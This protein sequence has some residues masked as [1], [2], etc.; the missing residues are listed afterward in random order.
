MVSNGAYLGGVRDIL[1]IKDRCRIDQHTGCWVWAYACDG[2]K[3]IC[4][5]RFR[6]RH[7]SMSAKRAAMIFSGHILSTKKVVMNRA[8]CKEPLCVNPEHLKIVS[9]SE[10]KSMS[11][12]GRTWD[13]ARKLRSRSKH[14]NSTPT[15]MVDWA[16]ESGQRAV[17]IAH[18]LGVHVSSVYNWRN[19]R[20]VSHPF[21]MLMA[22]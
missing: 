17:D 21:S 13:I 1:G 8:A 20:K 18:A 3:P 10:F 7:E 6:G 5:V 14:P 11:G 22:A 16:L 15:W 2:G 9:E 4:A 12:R 19:D